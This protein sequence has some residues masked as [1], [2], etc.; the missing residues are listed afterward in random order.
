MINMPNIS[1]SKC[2]LSVYCS[3]S[4]CMVFEM[5]ATMK[6]DNLL[7]LFERLLDPLSINGEY[8]GSQIMF[9][10]MCILYVSRSILMY[11]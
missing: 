7:L 11:I 4:Y 6:V 8:P 3:N 10:Q 5:S 9:V 2:I 1:S